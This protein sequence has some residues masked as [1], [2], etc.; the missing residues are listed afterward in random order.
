MISSLR[1]S[2]SL[3]L[4]LLMMMSIFRDVSGQRLKKVTFNRAL[5]SGYD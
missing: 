5:V 4:E 1:I 2:L 3:Q